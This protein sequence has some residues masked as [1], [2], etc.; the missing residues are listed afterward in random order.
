[1]EEPHLSFQHAAVKIVWA[2]KLINDLDREVQA[3]IEHKPYS[4]SLAPDSNGGGY[5]LQVNLT[6]PIPHQIPCLLGDICHNLRASA[7]FC[8]M[9]LRR[10]LD[11]S[12]QKDTLPICSNAKGL[13]TTAAKT[14]KDQVLTKVVDL[15]VNRVKSHHDFQAGGNILFAELNH[16]S[17][18][19][20]HNMLIPTFGVTE[21]GDNTVIKSNDG[22]IISLGR[23][24]VRGRVAGIG[25]THAEM[26][27]DSEPTVK[28]FFEAKY[29]G[30]HRPI[31]GTL[32]NFVETSRE[33][34]ETFCETWPSPSNPIFN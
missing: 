12:P 33:I 34:V 27:Y 13:E 23:A 31:I 19:Q 4:I 18:W 16:L 14:F 11:A 30:G 8:W 6:K 25:G 15:L 2:N 29:L 1:M 20:K 5:I 7:D 3:F 17:N 21:L 26:T 22:S 10:K 28:V 9:G 24:K 32:R